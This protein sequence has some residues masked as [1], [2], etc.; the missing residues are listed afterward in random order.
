M[1]DN[2]KV[3][4]V[5]PARGG[6]KGIRLKNIRTLNGVPLVAITGKVV[7]E[8]DIV[9]RAVVSTDHEEIAKIAAASGL[10]V[11]FM[12]PEDLSGDLIGDL[13]VLTHALLEME[14]QDSVLYNLIVMLQPTSPLRTADH[15]KRAIKKLV[16]TRADSVWT[17]SATDTKGHPLKQLLVESDTISYY[18][19]AAAGIT[20]RQQL[21][22]TYHKNGVAYVITRDCILNQKSIKGKKCVPLIIE[23][24]VANIDTEFDIAFAEF[25]T[26]YFKK[27]THL[28]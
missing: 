16:E 28:L 7:K 2:Q 27:D 26:N 15:V 11:P 17:V 1:I 4:V 8:I 23:E 9:D 13:E 5:V 20:A 14:R 10:D 25:I 21:N 6:S 24:F 19:E 18:D 12:R 22:R 3:L